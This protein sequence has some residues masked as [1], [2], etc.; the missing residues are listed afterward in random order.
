MLGAS[1]S[2]SFF[3]LIVMTIFSRSSGVIC[4]SRPRLRLFTESCLWISGWAMS[5]GAD[6]EEELSVS[7]SKAS[8]SNES[9]LPERLG[10][11]VLEYR[12]SELLDEMEIAGV[13]ALASDTGSQQKVSL[14][15]NLQ[16]KFSSLRPSSNEPA[17]LEKTVHML[18]RFSTFL[19]STLWMR[20]AS[21]VKTGVFNREGMVSD[22]LE[23]ASCY[24]SEDTT[25]AKCSRLTR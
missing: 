25:A 24:K 14:F 3:S 8:S 15:H 4:R 16:L 23:R 10:T 22:L 5:R 11:S 17:H 1:G 13:V 19:V 21:T 2:R 12:P 18:K 6:V 7:N 20:P 9:R